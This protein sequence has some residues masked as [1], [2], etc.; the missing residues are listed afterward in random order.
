MQEL[1]KFS[2]DGREKVNEMSREYEITSEELIVKTAIPFQTLSKMEI[3]HD[4]NIHTIARI[5]VTAKEEDQQ[6]ILSRDWTDT[7]I[8]V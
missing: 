8:T 6:E 2:P 4:I 3:R 7:E 1:E 5:S